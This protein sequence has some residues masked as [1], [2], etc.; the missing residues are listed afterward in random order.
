[1]GSEGIAEHRLISQT[2][3]L[4]EDMR[5]AYVAMTR[6]RNRCYLAWGKIRTSESS[7]LFHLLHEAGR[8]PGR[9]MGGSA[10]RD[11]LDALCAAAG[12]SMSVEDLPLGPPVGYGRGA[13]GAAPI[14]CRELSRGI[15]CS[16][17][18]TSFTSMVSPSLHH[19]DADRDP[20]GYL[21]ER[22]DGEERHDIF[23][24]PRGA[25]AG[26]MI[27]EIFEKLDFGSGVEATGS[28]I[29]EVLAGH[30]FAA[31]WHDV[32]AGMVKRVLAAD[33][34]GFSLSSVKTED[35]LRELEF[36]L[37]VV[38]ISPVILGRAFREAGGPSLPPSLPERMET[39]GFQES[40][41]FLR[42][43]MDLVFL[44]G[45]RYYLV[46]WKSNHLG[47]AVEDYCPAA[48]EEVMAREHYT[49]QYHLYTLALHRYL[50]RRVPGYSFEGHFG[51][52][53]YVFVRGVDRDMN[54]SSGIYRRLPERG[55]V[56]HLDALVLEQGCRGC[57]HD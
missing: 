2:E 48:I 22:D 16:F 44:H 15:D 55:L 4:A 28:L 49:L 46:D 1:M 27:H 5:L 56:E 39:L 9:D 24:L 23:S 53:F 7:A 12:G 41:G 11:D 33:L 17:R 20:A 19:G 13:S 38:R 52:V 8:E 50:K 21:N 3:A 43:F 47:D 26:T 40:R 45:S 54:P 29:R 37:P 32:L 6:A 25:R 30:G 51:G 35:T 57:G 36:T 18:I 42:G 34:G 14:R 31:Y 10:I